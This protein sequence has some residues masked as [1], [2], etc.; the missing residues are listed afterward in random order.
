[1]LFL[2]DK[3]YHNLLEHILDILILMIKDIGIYR[4]ITPFKVYFIII[5]R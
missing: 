5:Y 4:Y 3:E 1:M 2:K